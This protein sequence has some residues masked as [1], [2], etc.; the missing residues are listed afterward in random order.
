M[1]FKF[2]RRIDILVSSIG[3][4]RWRGNLPPKDKTIS[5]RRAITATYL[6]VLEKYWRSEA[7]G[8]GETAGEDPSSIETELFEFLG[9]K[10]NFKRRL[11][12][13]LWK[14]IK[15]QTQFQ[16]FPM[17]RWVEFVRIGEDYLN[18]KMRP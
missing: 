13:S 8:C 12:A 3:C 7:S 10:T 4:L 6:A 5:G 18:K 11:A 1:S 14:N 2:I 16:A 17:K 9:E 15:N